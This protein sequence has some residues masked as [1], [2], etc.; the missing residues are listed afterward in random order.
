MIYIVTDKATGAEAY[1]YQADAPIEWSG[2]SFATHDH[3][4]LVEVV[5]GIS[6][7]PIL[8]MVWTQTQW[9]RRFTQEERL[10]I[11]DAATQSPV[12]AD[13]MD[14]MNGADEIANDDPD[15]IKAMGLLEQAGLIDSGRAN[16]VLNG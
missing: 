1:R 2:M 11:R 5:D 12:L 4:E 14:L 10:A 7:A 9:K 15:V 13:Y 6:D 3:T 16:E 8:R